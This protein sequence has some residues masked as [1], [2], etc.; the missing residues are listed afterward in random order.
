LF[1]GGSRIVKGDHDRN[2]YICPGLA[3]H[4]LRLS[5]EIERIEFRTALHFLVSNCS[6]PIHYWPVPFSSIQ[7]TF[8]LYINI[9]L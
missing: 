1:L 9:P 3:R 7:L 5:K 4:M 6:L 2:I 8:H